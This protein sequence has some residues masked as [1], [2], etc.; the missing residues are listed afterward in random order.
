MVVVEKYKDFLGFSL[1][2][3]CAISMSSALLT[4]LIEAERCAIRQCTNICNLTAGKDHRTYD[5]S[6][7]RDRARVMVF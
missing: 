7:S 2:R 1:P 5:L 6:L 4:V 3:S